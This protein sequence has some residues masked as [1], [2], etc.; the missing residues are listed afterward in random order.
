L[1]RNQ[2]TAVPDFSVC[3]FTKISLLYVFF[4][5]SS[6]STL[7][8]REIASNQISRPNKTSFAGLSTLTYLDYTSN[9]LKDLSYDVFDELTSLQIL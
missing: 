4:K 9:G 7:F 3:S 8:C 6:S 5:K 2:L 1:S